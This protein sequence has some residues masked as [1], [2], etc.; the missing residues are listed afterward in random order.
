MKLQRKYVYIFSIALV[1][2]LFLTFNSATILR[3][4]WY[5]LVPPVLITLLVGLFINFR[6]KNNKKGVYL[7][8]CFLILFI[9]FIVFAV[10]SLASMCKCYSEDVGQ[11]IITGECAVVASVGSCC[12]DFFPWYYKYG[13]DDPQKLEELENSMFLGFLGD[14]LEA[15]NL[16]N[17][18]TN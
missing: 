15:Q 13:C 3:L 6:N 10:L 4:L 7:L 18:S 8:V 11:N 14:G 12:G 17:T 16:S 1:L 9:L 5:S 2:T